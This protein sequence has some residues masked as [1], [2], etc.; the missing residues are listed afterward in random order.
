M[1]GTRD[2]SAWLTVPAAIAF[3]AQHGWDQVAEAC[4]HLVQDTLRQVRNL[5]GLP[6][7]CSPEFC[8]PQ[9]GAMP[10]TRCDPLDLQRTLLALFY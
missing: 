6:G 2:P 1:Q 4:R 9:M 8:A 5:T 3:R 7:F 10:V